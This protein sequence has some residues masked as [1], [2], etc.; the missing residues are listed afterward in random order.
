[1]QLIPDFALNTQKAESQVAAAYAKLALLENSRQVAR[2]REQKH[3]QESVAES[4][5][6]L[7][8]ISGQLPQFPLNVSHLDTERSDV[9]T[10]VAHL[11]LV[12]NELENG[13]ASTGCLKHLHVATSTRL[14]EDHRT[15]FALKDLYQ[16]LLGER[17]SHRRLHATE[18][19]IGVRSTNSAK[20]LAQK[21]RAGASTER[22]LSQREAL[23]EA[24]ESKPMSV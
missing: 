20:H 1:M 10:R 7:I 16:Q 17:A 24:R 2:Y 12:K 8:A 9:S 11:R 21:A 4:M 5:L 15:C 22:L 3:R 14:H 19:V 6:H 23:R 13:F 18:L